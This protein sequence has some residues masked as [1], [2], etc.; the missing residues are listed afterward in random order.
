MGHR[1]H[2]KLEGQAW[3][4]LVELQLIL[5]RVLLLKHRLAVLRYEGIHLVILWKGDMRK[6]K[7]VVGWF[8]RSE[9]VGVD[10]ASGR[11]RFAS[12]G[13]FRL[14]PIMLLPQVPIA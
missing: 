1:G 6:G 8:E 14:S 11:V 2:G 13:P 4:R 5:L 9:V 7:S 3:S 10:G 12:T